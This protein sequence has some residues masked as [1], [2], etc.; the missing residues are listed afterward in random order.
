MSFHSGF[1]SMKK[2]FQKKYL[3]KLFSHS[4]HDYFANSS[5]H[6]RS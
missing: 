3:Q 5:L 6:V 1:E 2:E 4:K